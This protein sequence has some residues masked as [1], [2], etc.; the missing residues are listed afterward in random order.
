MKTSH[1]ALA[2]LTA[3]LLCVGNAV[4]QDE[5]KTESDVWLE[6]TIAKAKD[7]DAT[8]MY[9]L[10][11]M[12]ADGKGVLE[13]DK[14]AVKWFRKAADLGDAM[15]MNSLGV[16]YVHGEGV[17]QDDE[18]AVKWYRKAA[19]LGNANAMSNLGVMYTQGKGVIEDFK[20]AFKWFRKAAELGTVN[21]M[22]A[23]GLMYDNGD[24]VIEDDVEAY[25]WV[26]VAA[27]NGN[28][29]VVEYRDKIKNNMTTEQ[30]AEGQKRSRE[31]METIAKNNPPEAT[32]SNSTN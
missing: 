17:I 29:E 7:G 2:V 21:A 20:E 5:K 4:G 11:V 13:D 25:A 22:A 14:E 30:I 31:I 9:N 12:Y 8:A 1:F 23:L 28:K 26:N 18:E 27:A 10:G 6:E 19:E 32:Q 24:G 16:A 15:A 3:S